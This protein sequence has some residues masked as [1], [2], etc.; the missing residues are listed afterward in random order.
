MR[1][2]RAEMTLAAPTFNAIQ[3]DHVICDH[4]GYQCHFLVTAIHS[5]RHMAGF[6]PERGERPD[7]LPFGGDSGCG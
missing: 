7:F 1:R 4:T 5:P 2:L 3:F 6:H